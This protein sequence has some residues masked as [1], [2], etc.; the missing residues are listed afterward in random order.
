MVLLE[1]NQEVE[2]MKQKMRYFEMKVQEKL[3]DY[4]SGMQERV[5]QR[6]EQIQR[7]FLSRTERAADKVFQE[8]NVIIM[9]K[10]DEVHRH[11]EEI[12][13]AHAKQTENFE[14]LYESNEKAM[15]MHDKVNRTFKEESDAFFSERKK[16]KT[17]F[18]KTCE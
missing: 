17:E 15:E 8:K 7:A 13:K 16:W 10:L 3:D 4:E 18:I 11:F 2:R 12:R 1:N 5:E 9:A 14:V 6:L